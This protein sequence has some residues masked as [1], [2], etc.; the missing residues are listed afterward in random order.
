MEQ[1]L[2]KQVFL[3]GCQQVSSCLE[4]MGFRFA[5]SG[6]H[7]SR[8]AGDWTFKISFQ[9]S[10]LNVAGEYVELTVHASVS[11]KELRAWD[12]CS[13]WPAGAN[14]W[15]AGGQLGNL[16]LP[17]KWR[18]WNIAGPITRQAQISNVVA[19][20]KTI[21]LPFFERFSAPQELA[22]EVAISDVPGFER[23]E[24]AIRFVYWQLGRETAE[25]CISYWVERLSS[26][27]AF[28]TERDMPTL[29]KNLA[30]GSDVS[31]LA[32]IARAMKIGLSL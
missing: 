17:R 19:N 1:E 4:P 9:S 5:K 23:P 8:R 31:N 14:E 3:D 22:Q 27:E 18:T 2:P 20:I 32:R 26:R 24:H 15:V 10:N 21:I 13:A 6:P 29:P 12:E 16:R 25:N 28:R 7:V 11:S 30:F